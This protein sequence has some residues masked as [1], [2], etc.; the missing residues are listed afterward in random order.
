MPA[1]LTQ[2]WSRV[3]LHRLLLSEPQ[4]PRLNK[5]G[6]KAS[7]LGPRVLGFLEGKQLAQGGVSSLSRPLRHC[8]LV[9]RPLKLWKEGALVAGMSLS[10]HSS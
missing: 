5:A 9:M 6:T 3:Q 8:L 2:N 10:L 1:S 4:F 7:I